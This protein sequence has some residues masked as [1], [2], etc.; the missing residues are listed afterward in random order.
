MYVLYPTGALQDSM[1]TS[2]AKNWVSNVQAWVV[3]R[4]S[5]HPTLVV[6]YDQMVDDIEP[7]LRKIARFLNFPL[8]EDRIQCVVGHTMDAHRRNRK[9][10]DN[11]YT[12]KQQQIIQYAILSLKDV[13]E[14]H[15]IRYQD[16]QW[17][18]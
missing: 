7:E 3:R 17:Q 11:P 2:F 14:K 1:V 10:T 8:K 9:R 13:W 4:G 15:S 6:S 12:E 18:A 16:W 5:S